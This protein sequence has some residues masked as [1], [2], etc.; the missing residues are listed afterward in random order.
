[1]SRN[2][3]GFM[4]AIAAV[5]LCAVAGFSQAPLLI[6]LGTNVVGSVAMSALTLQ[7]PPVHVTGGQDTD[8]P[9]TVFFR[10]KVDRESSDVSASA[11]FSLDVTVRVRAST[12]AAVAGVTMAEYDNMSTLTKLQASSAVG[13]QLGIPRLR[14]VLT[15]LYTGVGTDE[16]AVS[17]QAIEPLGQPPSP[18]G[19]GAPSLVL[20]SSDAEA[21]AERVVV[22]PDFTR[23]AAELLAR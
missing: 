2:D 6:P 13:L 1:M 23:R 14:A 4:C 10:R 22:P 11:R 15:A 5:L 17:A 8:I 19:A 20:V 9:L 12:I 21:A 18:P 16:V 3:L 7:S